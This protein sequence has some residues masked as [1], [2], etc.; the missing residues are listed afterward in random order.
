MAGRIVYKDVAP[1][2]AAD[3]AYS[4]GQSTDF[5]TLQL[6]DTEN[7][8]KHITLERNRWVLD[9]SFTALGDKTVHYWSSA[10]SG[11]DC[12]LPSPAVIDVRFTQQH[13][14][15][16]V[17]L[18]FEEATG[19]YCSEVS[20]TWYQGSMV[21]ASETFYPDNATY[22]CGRRVEAYDRIV[23]SLQKTSLPRRRAKLGQILFGIVRVFGTD[24]LV[25][26]SAVNETDIISA[27][28]PASKLNWEINSDEDVN[29]MFQLKQ[30]V[31]MLSG[32]DLIGV[33]YIDSASKKSAT[34][35][36]ISAQ[37]AIGVL[38]EQE[39]PGGAYINGISAHQLIT[40]I[41]GG[42]FTVVF[43]NSA[44]DTT[45]Y[46]VLLKQTKREALQQV[47]L[48]WGMICT[49]AGSRE[50]RVLSPSSIPVVIDQDHVYSGATVEKSALVT[51]VSVTAHTYTQNTSGEVEINGTRYKDAKTVYTID[52]PNVTAA[53]LNNTV[54][55]DNATLVSTRNG[56]AVAQRVYNYYQR[57]DRSR[58]KVVY[59]GETLGDMVTVPSPWGTNTS[60]NIRLMSVTLSGT[61]A[62]EI[63]VVGVEE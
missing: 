2:A 62:A 47:L 40:T 5:S 34:D 58:A 14:S 19:E 57:R 22:F 44:A 56:Q 21:K 49:T 53:D 7:V 23:I 55:I 13:S 11:E 54:S 61:V 1:Y 12:V 27:S 20:I 43:D 51:R 24:K 28:L 16:G 8:E 15:V 26:A 4:S 41:V 30:P 10:I 33:Y 63:E 9:G 17:T 52:N 29:L 48:P 37:D 25:S 36:A 6:S 31:E 18:V 35:Y 50:I 59:G 46:G 45:L 3:A 60:G 39:F 42:A 32:S 38:G